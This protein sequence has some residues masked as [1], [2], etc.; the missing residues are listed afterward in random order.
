MHEDKH[1]ERTEYVRSL[2]Q[3]RFW[4]IGIRNALG[5][6]KSNCVKCR[7]LAVQAIHPHMADLPGERVEGNVYPFKSTGIDYFGSFEVTVLRRPVKHWCCLFSC[8]VTR[9]VHIEV[10][11]GLDTD[12]CVMA[13]TRVMA[14]R[15]KPVTTART[16]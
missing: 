14:R 13:I 5:S 11:N 16:S 6:I 10:V 8:L 9:A 12:A 3:Q 4:V 2:V 1:H 15:G 7:K